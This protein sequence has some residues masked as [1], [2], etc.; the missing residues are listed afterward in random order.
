MSM[1]EDLVTKDGKEFKKIHGMSK[2]K[3]KESYPH[4][5]G[6][7]AT[8]FNKGG[9]AKCGASVSGTQNKKNR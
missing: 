8:S 6:K 2:K 3:A 7:V 9:Y 1:K 4:T 5:A